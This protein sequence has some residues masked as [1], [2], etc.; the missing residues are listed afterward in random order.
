MSDTNGKPK[1]TLREHLNILDQN[2]TVTEQEKERLVN[3]LRKKLKSLG[4]PNVWKAAG[5]KKKNP[6]KSQECLNL[7]REYVD[8]IFKTQDNRCSFYLPTI[9][10]QLNGLWNRPQAAFKDWKKDNIVYEID[11]V[12]PVNAGGKDVLENYQFLS[13]NAN[14]FTKTSLTYEDLLRRVDLSDAL[15][16][17]IRTVLSRRKELFA[18]KQWK[19]FMTKFDNMEKSLI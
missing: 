7:L 16:D 1:I 6:E 10:D 9:G 8:L 4:Y 2:A 17:R 18:S 13:A 19:Q 12:V 3:V 14:Q 15:K 11:H 5:Q